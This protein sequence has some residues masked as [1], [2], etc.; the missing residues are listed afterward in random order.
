MQEHQAPREARISRP[1]ACGLA[2]GHD[3][4]IPAPASRA[5]P[6]DPAA[7]RQR[8]AGIDHAAG[9][10]LKDRRPAPRQLDP[11]PEA[12]W[13]D[14][15]RD[16]RQRVRG[17]LR[18]AHDHA[19]FDTDLHVVRHD[20]CYCAGD[21]VAPRRTDDARSGRRRARRADLHGAGP[22]R[23]AGVPCSGC[24]GLPIN[25]NRRLALPPKP[26]TCG[27]R[28]S[29]NPSVLAR[30]DGRTR[31]FSLSGAR[32]RAKAYDPETEARA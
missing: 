3:R 24:G 26:E 2:Q 12:G 21:A 8:L 14:H 27:P 4:S 28:I 30:T 17:Q 6:R 32:C 19:G 16:S 25:R 15:G 7:R 18:S 13:F 31:I 10:G 9:G 29:P 11:C 23:S 22:A 20:L 1:A 5:L